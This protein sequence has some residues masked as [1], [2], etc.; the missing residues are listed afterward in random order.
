MASLKQN[1]DGSVS[2]FSELEGIDVMRAGG[3]KTPTASNPNFRPGSYLKWQINGPTDTA[4]ALGSWQNT[5]GYDIIVT[6]V[7]LDV[8][9]QSAGACTVSVGQAANGTSLSGNIFNGQSVAATGQFSPASPA[10]KK[11]TAGQFI[12]ASTASGASS[13]LV[14]Q[15]YIEFVPA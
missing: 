3:P 13:G 5:L 12:T 7:C 6:G 2:I 14:G 10:A 9:T 11:V 4:G 15:L 1:A 8:T